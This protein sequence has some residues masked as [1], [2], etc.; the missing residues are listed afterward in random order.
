MEEEALNYI[1]VVTVLCGDE[2][3]ISAFRDEEPAMRYF[4]YLK[5]VNVGGVYID[6]CH[7]YNGVLIEEDD[8]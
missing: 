4:L 6:R 3:I 5:R 2:P 1:W 7:V 8:V